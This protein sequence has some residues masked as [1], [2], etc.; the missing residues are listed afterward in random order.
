MA[1][2]KIVFSPLLGP[3]ALLLLSRE[4]GAV[5]PSPETE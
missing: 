1:E 3:V 4:G 5:A 2:L